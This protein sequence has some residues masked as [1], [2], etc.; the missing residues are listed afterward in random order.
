MPKKNPNKQ[1]IPQTPKENRAEKR[2]GERNGR[3]AC[4]G[5]NPSSFEGKTRKYTGKACL[6]TMIISLFKNHNTD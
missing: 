3:A 4:S 2:G 5:L 1:K 6:Y